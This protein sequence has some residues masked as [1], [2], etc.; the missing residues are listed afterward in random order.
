[1]FDTAA[2]QRNEPRYNP[3]MTSCVM[4]TDSPIGPKD[5]HGAHG[6]PL[7]LPAVVLA[8]LTVKQRREVERKVEERAPGPSWRPTVLVVDS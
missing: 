4:V 8:T 1:M 2:D 5:R 7:A 6:D 3:R